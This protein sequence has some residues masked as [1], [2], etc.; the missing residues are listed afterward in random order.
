MEDLA[1]G[2]T[3]TMGGAA[4]A[5]G[6][7]TEVGVQDNVREGLKAINATLASNPMQ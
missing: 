7:A 2:L 5:V 4:E 3:G 1:T 6:A